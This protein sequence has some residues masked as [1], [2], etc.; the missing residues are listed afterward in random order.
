[1]TDRAA[2]VRR[3]LLRYVVEIVERHDL[4]PWA[5]G[6]RE[7]GELA[8]E[9]VWGAPDDA[10]W[11]RAARGALDRARVVMVVAP[12]LAISPGG[13]RALRDRVAAA[14]PDAGVAD[15]HPEAPLDLGSPARL[16]PFLRRAPDP[17]LQLVPHAILDAVRAQQPLPARTDQIQMLRDRAAPPRPAIAERIAE[18]NHAHVARVADAIAATLA[19][20]AADRAASYERIGINTSR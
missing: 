8:I 19:D 4:C 11:L 18:A 15:F 14:I 6:A 7:A 10:A 3:I 9:V 13:L 17:V 20:V 1:V 5:R 12:E 16:V 2:E